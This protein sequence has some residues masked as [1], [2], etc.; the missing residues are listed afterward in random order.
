MISIV[1][2]VRN[3]APTL[4]KALDSVFEQTYEATQLIVI[5]GASTD[6]TQAI[7]ERNAPRITYWESKP[8]RGISHAWN[9][10]LSRASGEW[11][12]FL[13]ADDRFAEPDVM[14]RIARDLS[15]A[16]SSI[17]VA[18]A[19]VRLV[20]RDGSTMGIRAS[21]GQRSVTNSCAGW[22]SRIKQRS[23]GGTY[24]SRTAISM[25]RSELPATMNSS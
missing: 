25:S 13:G 4:Q 7:L 12:C 11:V 1:I 10:A 19:Q 6:G 23:T 9:K 3:A 17:R 22:L 16:A 5:D 2:A 24:S 21:P 8:D 20:S 18:Y 15:E 14:A